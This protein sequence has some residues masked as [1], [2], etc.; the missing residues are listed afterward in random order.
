MG[1]LISHVPAVW[2]GSYPAMLLVL[3]GDCFSEQ[4]EQYEVLVPPDD[5]HVLLVDQQGYFRDVKAN[6]FKELCLLVH[7]AHPINPVSSAR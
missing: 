7:A 5:A 2:I 4:S 1:L 6:G 3:P